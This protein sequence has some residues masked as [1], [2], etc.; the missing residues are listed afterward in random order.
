MK[1][2]VV[3]ASANPSPGVSTCEKAPSVTASVSQTDELFL[4][5]QS[6]TP[7]VPLRSY[8]AG[9]VSVSRSPVPSVVAPSLK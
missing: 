9:N 6:K 8:A 7:S 4:I 5:P 2:T 1:S 3:G